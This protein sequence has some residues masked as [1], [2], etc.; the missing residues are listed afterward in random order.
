MGANVLRILDAGTLQ[1]RLLRSF[2]KC[3]LQSPGR[4]ELLRSWLKF[5]GEERTQTGQKK[6]CLSVCNLAFL[7]RQEKAYL[8]RTSLYL[9]ASASA[10]FFADIALCPMEAVK[11]RIQTMPG[12]AGTLREGFPIILNNEGFNGYV[13]FSPGSFLVEPRGRNRRSYGMIWSSLSL[14]KI[15]TPFPPATLPRS[16][17]SQCRG[18]ASTFFSFFLDFNLFF[19]KINFFFFFFFFFY[20]SVTFFS[21][22][23]CFCNFFFF[24]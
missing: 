22:F 5:L 2:Q 18:Q 3:L 7:W 24:F 20:A 1:V 8:W 10:E 12:F 23:F 9:A 13:L 14:R 16:S 6:K 4:G 21:F 11:V 17:S 15:L 19:A